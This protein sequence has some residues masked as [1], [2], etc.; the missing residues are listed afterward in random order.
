MG[1][2]LAW[3]VWMTGGDEVDFF[4]FAFG[5]VPAGSILLLMLIDLERISF[6][7]RNGQIPIGLEPWHW[8]RR[9]IIVVPLFVVVVSTLSPLPPDLRFWLSKPALD[10]LAQQVI[11][12]GDAPDQWVGLYHVRYARRLGGNGMNFRLG[13]W[14]ENHGLEYVKPGRQPERDVQYRHLGGDWYLFN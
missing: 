14:E 10:R 1:L 6:I 5:V 3:L 12:N 4:S 2:G 8:R 11:A 7:L 13:H 9:F